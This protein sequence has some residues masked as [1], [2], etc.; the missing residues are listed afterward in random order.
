MASRKI[1]FEIGLPEDVIQIK[2][3]K[4]RKFQFLFYSPSERSLYQIPVPKIKKLNENA[5]GYIIPRTSDGKQLK[6]TID[7]I[8]RQLDDFKANNE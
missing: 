4:G 1:E 7:G 2:Q 3:F 5:E 8:E 6:L